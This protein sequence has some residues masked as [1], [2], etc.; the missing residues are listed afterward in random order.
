MRSRMFHGRNAIRVATEKN[1]PLDDAGGRHIGNIETDAN[2]HALLL[3]IRTKVGIAQHLPIKGNTDRLETPELQHATTNREKWFGGQRA[4]PFIAARKLDHRSGDGATGG[5]LKRRTIIEENTMTMLF[6]SKT[7]M[8]QKF[9]IV[10][11]KRTT[12]LLGEGTDVP[13]I[14]QQNCLQ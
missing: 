13:P 14:N 11:I 1:D 4:K 5:A 8:R 9:N 6:R 12:R 10:R 7:G 3:E 2:I